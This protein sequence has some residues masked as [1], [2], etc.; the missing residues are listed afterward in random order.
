MGLFSRVLH[1]L[2]ERIDSHGTFLSYIVLG[3]F[4]LLRRG[5]LDNLNKEVLNS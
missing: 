1:G 2:M 3:S 5:N 4:V